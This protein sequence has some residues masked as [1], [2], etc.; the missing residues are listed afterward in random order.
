MRLK[1]IEDI[2]D[3]QSKRT[4]SKRPRLI[5]VAWNVH[6]LINMAPT[7]INVIFIVLKGFLRYIFLTSKRDY[8]QEMSG[9]S[10]FKSTQIEDFPVSFFDPFCGKGS[11]EYRF[12]N[13]MVIFV[14]TDI[15]SF[16]F[17]LVN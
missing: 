2:N 1:N 10:D 9:L 7:I 14:I 5:L 13:Y 6:V 11:F 15:V 16:Y 17:K 8:V 4:I 3:P 12:V